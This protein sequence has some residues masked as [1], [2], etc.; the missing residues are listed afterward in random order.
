MET[1]GIVN[2]ISLSKL[3]VVTYVL[4][5]FDL[6]VAQAMELL[7]YIDY[8][9]TESDQIDQMSDG[10]FTRRKVFSLEEP[11]ELLIVQEIEIGYE[12]L[13]IKE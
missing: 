12:I 10:T 2:V 8:S 6:A 13:E 5:D 11:M 1:V 7:K 3:S 4:R 9:Y